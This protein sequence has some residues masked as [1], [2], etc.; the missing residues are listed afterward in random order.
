MMWSLESR[1]ISGLLEH[2]DKLNGTVLAGLVTREVDIK[3]VI[4]W[5]GSSVGHGQKLV[6]VSHGTRYIFH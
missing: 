2:D 1:T 6:R 5:Y 3:I 4:R